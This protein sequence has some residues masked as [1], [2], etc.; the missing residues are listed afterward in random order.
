MT[1]SII[2]PT[3]NQA[4][5]IEDTFKSILNQ[6]V[7]PHRI[8]YIVVDGLSTD[9]TQQIVKK[10]A[11]LFKKNNIDFRYI[12]EK[13]DGQTDAIIKGINAS[14]G[15]ILAYLNSDDYYEPDVLSSVFSFFTSNKLAWAYGGWN[16]VSR[17]GSLISTTQH[18]RF[19]TR[20][21]YNFCNIGQPSCFF[22]RNLYIQVNG[23]DKK[24]QLCM[25]Y[26]LWLQFSK[27]MPAGII[28]GVL[29]NMRYYSQTKSGMRALDQMKEMLFV[30]ERYTRTFSIQR[31]LQYFYFLRGAV[32]YFLGLD[33][34]RRVL[35]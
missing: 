11:P 24:L 27:I 17:N 30:Q 8:E 3:F 19:N 1:L 12:R 21:L 28:H 32:L 20:A 18:S 23:F 14:T 2:T 29:S 16:I 25:D 26:D 10:Y 15:E 5:F 34:N 6:D 33:Y 13:D 4:E 22:L 31:L 9:G 7:S 35:R